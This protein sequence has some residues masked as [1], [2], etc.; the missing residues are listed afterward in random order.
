MNKMKK[1]ILIILGFLIIG[2]SILGAIYMNIQAKERLYFYE[3]ASEQMKQEATDA[4]ITEVESLYWKNWA[5][6]CTTRGLVQTCSL[7]T[8][9]ATSISDLRN[10][11]KVDCIQ[12]NK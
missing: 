5:S 6:E 11:E 4:C 3:K 8:T 7:P 2:G 10:K 12:K 1:E 9:I